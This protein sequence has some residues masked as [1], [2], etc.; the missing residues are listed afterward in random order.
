[1]PAPDERKRN[2]QTRSGKRGLDTPQMPQQLLEQAT[3]FRE[4]AQRA[5]TVSGGVVSQG[6]ITQADVNTTWG[7]A[8]AVTGTLV[9]GLEFASMIKKDLTKNEK[10]KIEAEYQE[11]V[12]AGEDAETIEKWSNDLDPYWSGNK[13]PILEMQ[14]KIT[15]SSWKER[16][17]TDLENLIAQNDLSQQEQLDHLKELRVDYPDNQK[18]LLD[19]AIEAAQGAVNNVNTATI[20]TAVEADVRAQ[21]APALQGTPDEQYDFW[22]NHDLGGMAFADPTDL[23]AAVE[24]VINGQLWGAEGVSASTPGNKEKLVGVSNQ[25]QQ[26]VLASIQS[27]R[28]TQLTN[29][30]EQAYDVLMQRALNT[31][32]DAV[33]T[34]LNQQPISLSHL[35]GNNPADYMKKSDDATAVVYSSSF[36]IPLEDRPKTFA[37]P[38]G[39]VRSHWDWIADTRSNHL[40][41]LVQEALNN[42]SSPDA[43][44][45]RRL[46]YPFT[47]KGLPA[48]TDEEGL[49]EWRDIYNVKTSELQSRAVLDYTADVQLAIKTASEN[50]DPD[51][52]LEIQA[53]LLRTIGGPDFAEN[54]FSTLPLESQET[55]R[56]SIAEQMKTMD[57]DPATIQ[58]VTNEWQRLRKDDP[59]L[60]VAELLKIGEDNLKKDSERRAGAA[61]DKGQTLLALEIIE[62]QME[63]RKQLKKLVDLSGSVIVMTSKART[64]QLKLAKDSTDHKNN[65]GGVATINAALG[66][67]PADLLAANLV[68]QT[69]DSAVQAQSDALNGAIMSFNP[70]GVDE[71]GVHRGTLQAL[72]EAEPG[73]DKRE[74][75]IKT[76]LDSVS[77]F[78][79]SADTEAALNDIHLMEEIARDA[80]K[81]L[82]PGTEAHTEWFAKLSPQMKERFPYAYGEDGKLKVKERRPLYE[83]SPAGARAAVDT[84]VSGLASPTEEIQT[85]IIK[86]ALP[87]F[88]STI[89][90]LDQLMVGGVLLEE[91][92]KFQAA[93]QAIVTLYRAANSGMNDGASR[94]WN[95]LVGSGDETTHTLNALADI[96]ALQSN[97]DTSKLLALPPAQVQEALAGFNNAWGSLIYSSYVSRESIGYNK[98]RGKNAEEQIDAINQAFMDGGG[99]IPYE[100]RTSTVTGPLSNRF[101]EAMT[102]ITGSVNNSG[103]TDSEGNQREGWKEGEEATTMIPKGGKFIDPITGEIKTANSSLTAAERTYATTITPLAMLRVLEGNSNFWGTQPVDFMIDQG[104]TAEALLENAL[105][106]GLTKESLA[107]IEAAA[108]IGFDTS[109]G[110]I[111]RLFAGP[112]GASRLI[113][114]TQSNTMRQGISRPTGPLDEARGVQVLPAVEP[115]RWVSRIDKPVRH[116]G[117][118]KTFGLGT[119]VDKPRGYGGESS[120]L[121]VAVTRNNNMTVHAT[122]GGLWKDTNEDGNQ[123]TFVPTGNAMLPE[124]LLSQR[125]EK[126]P[127]DRE[128]ALA[129]AG[130]GK[131]YINA[132]MTTNEVLGRGQVFT[133][134]RHHGGENVLVNTLKGLLVGGDTQRKAEVALHS[135][136]LAVN[137]VQTREEADEDGYPINATDKEKLTLSKYYESLASLNVPDGLTPAQWGYRLAK[138]LPED[139]NWGDTTEIGPSTLA[140]IFGANRMLRESGYGG[141]TKLDHLWRT[142]ST[143]YEGA[144][145]SELT[146]QAFPFQELTIL[147]DDSH[148]DM[149]RRR[150]NSRG[151]NNTPWLK[152]IIPS[153]R[154]NGISAEVIQLHGDTRTID[155]NRWSHEVDFVGPTLYDE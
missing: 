105:R 143:K 102:H 66:V 79:A 16:T 78:Y 7:T 28:R 129:E 11:R 119:I 51:K 4:T 32:P 120:P 76:L 151:H 126:I 106:R 20:Q 140:V 132:S 56:R 101:L 134:H 104:W 67:P 116:T 41:E 108:S 60:T 10:D 5:G 61:F 37:G 155:S 137:I 130:T 21:W 36:H 149:A 74:T 142:M 114:L 42:P 88:R 150:G 133:P 70:M 13:T 128:R 63:A 118:L 52:M 8:N 34:Q 148:L 97:E 19:K 144:N 24:E 94:L 80:G 33:G 146:G 86:T 40:E 30:G 43:K 123:D 23:H 93:T 82:T 121:F 96:S 77:P 110:K 99:Y 53:N 131:G 18:H 48:V 73:S 90:L 139:T 124:D 89:N 83:L 26:N 127:V 29:L 69:S 92:P 141:S 75:M 91:A 57:L 27:F 117:E 1:M 81:T 17:A 85:A 35:T 145:S 84:L 59:D 65:T 49:Q 12:K 109:G 98:G 112:S 87:E 111:T 95:Q 25:L 54:M 68:L 9:Q 115:N 100:K 3:S 47:P 50:G 71:N 125:L 15:N 38:N 103:S 138:D 107:V 113:G 44:H 147:H 153:D 154:N 152:I 46:G 58:E 14:N 62:S 55:V 6:Q 122:L 2:N 64:A 22:M 39:L 31:R 135:Y 72:I 45:L 136:S